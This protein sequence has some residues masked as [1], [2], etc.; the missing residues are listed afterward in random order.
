MSRR[1][2]ILLGVLMAAVPAAAADKW[3]YAASEH[4]E[5][6]TTAGAR[7]ARD[8]LTH[9]ERV[10]A[11]YSDYFK[12]TPRT[13]T[14][15]RLIVFS[16]DRE[17]R[18]YRPNEAAAAYY[19]TGPDRDYIVMRSF[20]EDSN[21]TVVHEYAHLINRHSG[22]KYP[23]WLEEGFAE[24]FSTMEPDGDR[25]KVGTPGTGLLYLR[26][27]TVPLMDLP[28]LF[29]VGH[30]SKEY[31][32]KAHA[33]LF[34]A[35]SWALTHM[36][37]TDNAYI[38]ARA[39]FFDLI[40]D[41]ASSAAAMEKAFGKTLSTISQNL[42]NHVRKD[43]YQYFSLP[44]KAAP[45]TQRIEPRTVEPF[46]GDLVTANLL[47]SSMNREEEARAAFERLSSQKPD[48]LRLIEARAY[49]ELRRGE[50]RTAAS[51]LDRAVALG[52][53][54]PSVYKDYARV[55][56]E[57]ADQLLT[58]G[59]ALV[60]EDTGMRLQLASVLMA[61]GRNGQALSLLVQVK[62]IAPEFGFDY[63]QTLA[64]VYV[65]LNELDQARSAAANAVKHA[66]PGDEAQFAAR[67]LKT[68]EEFTARRAEAEA[69]L[70]R[71]RDAAESSIADAGPSVQPD[72]E[73]PF[74]RGAGR[75][76][77]DLRVV[78]SGRIRNMVC[79]GSLP[80]L[81]IA[82]GTSTIRLVIDDGL[83][84]SVIGLATHTVDL[85]CGKQDVPVRIGYQP[86]V[87]PGRKT[88]GNV[89]LLD[90]TAQ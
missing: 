13:A 63:F 81:E 77:Q 57:K 43:T 6:Y 47:A 35:Q 4:F 53:R 27:G 80:I 54:N 10:H 26:S 60:P 61:A 40:Q 1:V 34:Y 68:I 18:P 76:A 59:L 16:G 74:S 22:A 3:T 73:V 23:V 29:E 69:Q 72:V 46:E 38:P 79:G 67:L 71:V 21:Q 44:Y 17:F 85:Q 78:V 42:N 66:E 48:D 14:P 37:L 70:A 75:E 83:K 82:T 62:Q 65:R 88:V 90:Y 64:N 28:A 52:S 56:P 15:T 45:R 89:R 31:S 32:T 20:D 7:T 84:I 5:V 30:G 39:A 41:G 12:L 55:A 87:D 19:H 33:G 58:A 36:I 8:V 24:F 51:Y 50:S 2:A 25:M 11:F 86:V 49:F 9:F